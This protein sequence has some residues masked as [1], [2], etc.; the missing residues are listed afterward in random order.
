ME[1]TGFLR[2]YP[3][4][5]GTQ[6]QIV[7]CLWDVAKYE[8]LASYFEYY[9]EQ[10]RIALYAQG[11][12]KFAKTHQH[13]LDIASHLQNGSSRQVLKQHLALHHHG[14]NPLETENMCDA[15]IDLAVRLILMLDVGELRNAFSGRRRLVWVDGSLQ[16][17]VRDIFSDKISLNHDGVRFGAPFTARNLDRITGFRVELTTNLADHLRLRSENKIVS[18]FHHASF[19]RCQQ[20]NTMFPDGFIEETLWTLALLFPQGDRDTEKWYYKQDR[21]EELDLGVLDC[22]ILRD[23]YRQIEKYKFW[24]D[25][26]VILKGA[27]DECQPQTFSQLWNDRREGTQWYALWV[28]I[29]I[30]LF[31]G[32]IQSIE[33]AVQVYKAYHPSP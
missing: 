1:L 19:L 17:F 15:L 16:E 5:A 9:T 13:I 7:K 23:D 6:E 11:L 10:C 30:T 20:K 22:G 12:Q 29:G 3:I 14:E 28:A 32:L 33:G 25:R 21:P 27:F 8:P 2:D 4:P 24:H 18:V 26:L 31:F